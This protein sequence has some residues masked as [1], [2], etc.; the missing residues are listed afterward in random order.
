MDPGDVVSDDVP[1]EPI[2]PPS[3]S[4]RFPFTDWAQTHGI[5]Y[6]AEFSRELEDLNMEKA[7]EGAIV[8]VSIVTLYISDAAC[9][10]ADRESAVPRSL[11]RPRDNLQKPEGPRKYRRHVQIGRGCRGG[12]SRERNK[13]KFIERT[14]GSIETVTAPHAKHRDFTITDNPYVGPPPKSK[15]KH[16]G[17]MRDF[18][19]PSTTDDVSAAPQTC[20][21]SVPPLPSSPGDGHAQAASAS[22]PCT[23][24]AHIQRYIDEEGYRLVKNDP[25]CVALQNMQWPAELT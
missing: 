2:G 19:W 1:M 17:H 7:Y 18:A 12:P 16:L 3:G 23:T 14:L 21:P 4:T 6:S 10:A 5:K 15:A 11:K 22:Q 25:T 9:D 8:M 13:E 24:P 20:T